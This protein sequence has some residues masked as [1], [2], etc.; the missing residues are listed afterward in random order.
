MIKNLILKLG[1]SELV[2][3]LRSIELSNF[4]FMGIF[5][6]YKR[7]MFIIADG[8]N[9]ASETTFLAVCYQI[10]GAI[11][12]MT[13]MGATTKALFFGWAGKVL[14][15]FAIWFFL[16]FILLDYEKEYNRE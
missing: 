8:H 3:W 9:R 2:Q 7:V 16:P 11:L 5:T 14:M 15:M 4:N 12:I 13:F 10:F 1:N 6:I